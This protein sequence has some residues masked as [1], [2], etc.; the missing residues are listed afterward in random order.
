MVVT[1]AAMLDSVLVDEV[2][3]GYRRLRF[4]LDIILVPATYHLGICSELAEHR[5]VNLVEVT[6]S[7]VHFKN[8]IDKAHSVSVS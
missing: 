3:P 4:R 8:F 1:M 5:L 2:L 6:L 7:L